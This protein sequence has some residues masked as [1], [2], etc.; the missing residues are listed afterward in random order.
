MSQKEL[1]YLEDAIGH[2]KA[3]IA[4]L[5]NAKTSLDDEDLVDFIDDNLKHHQS[6]E[7]KLCKILEDYAN[8]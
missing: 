1:L 5:E 4:Y 3:M 6:L 7:K 8:E 2:E